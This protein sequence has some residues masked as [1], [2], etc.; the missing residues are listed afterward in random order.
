MVNDG[1][2]HGM[3]RRSS[4]SFCTPRCRWA[5]ATRL[6][7]PALRRMGL[8]G[9]DSTYGDGGQRASYVK[10]IREIV[11]RRSA[12]PARAPWRASGA[13]SRPRAC[14]RSMC[15]DC[16]YINEAG[17]GYTARITHDLDR[18]RG[19]ADVPLRRGHEPD[20]TPAK[21]SN[22]DPGAQAGRVQRDLPR[23]ERGRHG[24]D[25]A[26]PDSPHEQRAF[27]RPLGGHRLLG[28]ASS[29]RPSSTARS[30]RSSN[31]EATARIVAAEDQ[32]RTPWT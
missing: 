30:W 20:Q 15:L 13:R 7:S 23:A 5:L 3:A 17:N 25:R 19:P 32:V 12:V 28:A 14:S 21:R 26:L 1:A 2:G 27:R 4:T 24:Y 11:P 8:D 29:A 31:L 16:G 9:K 6:R 22:A 10:L 18:E